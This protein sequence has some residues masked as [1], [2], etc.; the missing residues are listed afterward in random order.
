MTVR[1]KVVA[2]N[3]SHDGKNYLYLSG[4]YEG[5]T[6]MQKLSENYAFGDATPALHFS[7][8]GVL[9][10]LDGDDEYYVDFIGV[11]ESPEARGQI[12]GYL[13]LLDVRKSYRSEPPRER[14]EGHY[15]S[16]RFVTEGDS[17]VIANLQMSVRNQ[18]AV[19]YLD[20]YDN[21]VIGLRPARGKRSAVEIAHLEKLMADHKATVWK[22]NEE[23]HN[24]YTARYEKK[25]ARYRGTEA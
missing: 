15:D 16:Y 10:V 17:V 20:K 13:M 21:F 8:E 23:L 2:T 18:T 7:L 9:P 24:T 19:E 14:T 5:S 12:S 6:E 1:A 25:L 22:G 3:S 4:V 11:D